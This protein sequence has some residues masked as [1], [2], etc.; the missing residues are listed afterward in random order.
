MSDGDGKNY[1]HG[2]YD[3]TN[4]NPPHQHGGTD[5]P[6]C[7]TCRPGV[8]YTTRNDLGVERDAFTATGGPTVFVRGPYP[9]KHGR[10][11][12]DAPDVDQTSIGPIDARDEVHIRTTGPDGSTEESGSI[13]D[14]L[15]DFDV[16]YN[17]HAFTPDLTPRDDPEV[18]YYGT[19]AHLRGNE[20]LRALQDRARRPD[21]SERP[22]WEREYGNRWVEPERPDNNA[23]HHCSCHVR[24]E[25]C[26][27]CVAINC[28]VH[29]R[30]M[31]VPTES[32]GTEGESM[33]S[34]S[35]SQW[36][37]ICST[38][39]NSEQPVYL[40]SGTACANCGRTESPSSADDRYPG[41]DT[42]QLWSRRGLSEHIR[43]EL[44]VL[45]IIPGDDGFVRPAAEKS[46]PYGD[47]FWEHDCP[48]MLRQEDKRITLLVER[49]CAEC[50]AKPAV[51][52]KFTG[53]TTRDDLGVEPDAFKGGESGNIGG[54]VA[55]PMEPDGDAPDGHY[56]DGYKWVEINSLQPIVDWAKIHHF[57]VRINGSWTAFRNEDIEAVRKD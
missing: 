46:G 29:G 4:D 41:G 18:F 7:T 20:L 3:H 39:L 35:E 23:G 49:D 54:D 44:Q 14:L 25:P 11:H 17:K 55:P 38:L 5:A 6:E 52:S 57:R 2:P 26:D 48:A 19:A 34:R 9:W 27:V 21:V 10:E 40:E 13:E 43:L 24:R 45:G 1:L 42:P 28:T 51:R 8:G 16:D 32:G 47:R 22:N 15:G 56:W 31:G 37:H 33:E 50:G 36:V 53:Y 30:P 12:G